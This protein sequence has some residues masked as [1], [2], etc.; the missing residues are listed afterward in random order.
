MGFKIVSDRTAIVCILVG[1]RGEQNNAALFPINERVSSLAPTRTV[2]LL[3][4]CICFNM[5]SALK[6]ILPVFSSSFVL[7]S[8]SVAKTQRDGPL[9]S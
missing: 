5:P 9:F 1:G 3:H 8:P 2:H 7:F 6:F 4:V